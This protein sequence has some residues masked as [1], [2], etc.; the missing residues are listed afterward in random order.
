MPSVYIKTYGCQMNERD[1]EAVGAQLVA[2]GYT[3]ARSEATADVVLLNTCSVRDNAEQ[4]A[5]NKMENIA[6]GIRKNRPDVVLG[7]MGCMAQSRGKALIDR[8]PDVDLVLGTQKFHRAAEYVDDLLAGR[9]QQVVDT[10]SETGSEA[11]IREHLLGGSARTSVS[12]F[13]SIMQGCNQ[14]C[15]F[16]IVPYTRGEERSRT[17]PDIVAECRELVGRGVKEI[18]LLG[19]IVTSYGRRGDVG[20]GENEPGKT[21]FVRLLE[22]VHAID[23]LERIRFTSP[24]P[25]GYGDDLVAAYGSL[26][27]LC[28]SAHIPVQ[29]GSNRIL[30]L[31]HRGYTRERFLEIIRKLREVQPGIG[32]TSDIIVGFPGETE[33]DFEAT[34]SLVREVEF[35]N[36]FLFK[37]SQRKDT[38]AAE[39]PDQ[40]SQ[41]VI[42]ERH[43][44]LLSL[45]NELGAR[46]YDA[47]KQRQVQ[48]LVEGHSKK[49]AARMMGRTRCNRIVL[50]EGSERHRGQL[51][52]V[53][54]ERVGSFTLYGDPAVVNL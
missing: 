2:K 30:K 49:N 41:D 6:A 3:L 46:R 14:Y 31:M 9:R 19:Q 23:G 16:C 17:I 20:A 36:A 4:K 48:I 43:A 8:L 24:H 35:D 53:R 18:T 7:F 32:L 44:R 52:D 37:Y 34:L 51:M 11:A 54:V 1:S 22:A 47:F 39:M 10:D 42:E 40:I 15:T 26:P 29:S 38:P 5:I 45:V 13:V 33:S 28:E 50:F 25:K 12:A 21:P 27:K